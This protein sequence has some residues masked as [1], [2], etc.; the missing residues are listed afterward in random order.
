MTPF[1]GQGRVWLVA[2]VG[3]I[4][5]GAAI[6]RRRAVGRLCLVIL[7]YKLMVTVGFFGYARQAASIGPVLALLAALALDALVDWLASLI[8]RRAG[9]I[10]QRRGWLVVASIVAL[11]VAVDLH[12]A[13]HAPAFDIQGPLRASPEWGESSFSSN[14]TI[15]LRPELQ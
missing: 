13:R 3:L 2:C 6:A 14:A 12:A 11:G 9:A 10:G 4:I 1:P 7:A 15:E 8:G 5:A